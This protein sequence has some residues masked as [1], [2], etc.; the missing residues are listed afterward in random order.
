[1]SDIRTV[2]IPAKDLPLRA[3]VSL[4]GS[5]VGEV[6]VD[7]HGPDLLE[8]VEAVRKASISRRDGDGED[9]AL[10]DALAGLNPGEAMLL[11]QAFASYLRA[12]NL[13]E[14]VHRIRRR[15]TYQRAG[16]TAQQGSLEAILEQL[17][18]QGAGAV[19]IA[20]A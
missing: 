6:L 16:A 13:A 11:I 4:L 15:R 5:L 19:C 18:D 17:K 14:R 8:R 10:D 3:D 1:M 9:A 12:V 2:E 20:E 7:Q